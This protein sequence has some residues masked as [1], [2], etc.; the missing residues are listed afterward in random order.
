MLRGAHAGHRI[1]RFSSPHAAALWLRWLREHGGRVA[2]RGFEDGQL[3][4]RY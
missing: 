3:I 1:K 2:G 4:I